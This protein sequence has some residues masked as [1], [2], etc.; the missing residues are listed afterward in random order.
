MQNNA[1]PPDIKAQLVTE[2]LHRFSVL[3]YNQAPGFHNSEHQANE[4][5]RLIVF[6]T[7]IMR[8]LDHE[9]PEPYEAWAQRILD[10]I[11]GTGAWDDMTNEVKKHI[12]DAVG[13]ECIAKIEI[14]MADCLS[15][16]NLVDDL[17][18]EPRN[19]D[20]RLSERAEPR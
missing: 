4:A 13:P 7:G 6:L 18:V 3:K 19:T 8:K 11:K 15:V 14:L 17:H 1:V 20:G 12:A 9:W 5:A 16:L 2:A 10:T